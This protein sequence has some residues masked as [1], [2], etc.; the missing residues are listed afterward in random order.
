MRIP[1]VVA[2][3][4][5]WSL[6]G[7]WSAGG[8]LEAHDTDSPLTFSWFPAF[9]RLIAHDI[10][11]GRLGPTSGVDTL[12]L[13]DSA[14][15][16]VS[17]L[18]ARLVRDRDVRVVAGREWILLNRSSGELTGTLLPNREWSPSERE[19]IVELGSWDA[20]R[21]IDVEHVVPILITRATQLTNVEPESIF[22]STSSVGATVRVNFRVVGGRFVADTIALVHR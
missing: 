16:T 18:G 3:A 21:G 4:Q 5:V 15:T 17:P 2:G 11:W 13:P 19:G 9:G 1:E 14:Q 12:S 7:V 6:V 20:Y 10:S 22:A 8:Q